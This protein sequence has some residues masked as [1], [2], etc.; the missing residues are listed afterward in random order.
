MRRSHQARDE[1]VHRSFL[2]VGPVVVTHEMQEAVGEEVGHLVDEPAPSFASLTR[3]RIE[4]HDDV[5]EQ[6]RTSIG[7]G[8]GRR[9]EREHVGGFRFSAMFPIEELDGR[10]VGEKHTELGVAHTEVFEHALRSA[11]DAPSTELRRALRI[12]RDEDGH[13]IDYSFG[14]FFA[15]SRNL[16]SPRSVSGCFTSC[17]ITLNGMVQMSAPII[18]AWTTCIG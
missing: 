1:G 6:P 4:R 2:R 16:A 12:V 9:S 10:I 18:A 5:A 14:I 15:S 17:A 7:L 13:A 3:G 11:T 8:R